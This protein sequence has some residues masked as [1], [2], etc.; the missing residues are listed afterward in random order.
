MSDLLAILVIAA[1][2]LLLFLLAVAESSLNGMSRSRANALA[3][4][5]V[6]GAS[7]LARGLEDRGLLLAP[8]LALALASQLSVGALVG[9]VVSR[10]FGAGWVPVG[11]L[12]ALLVMFVATEAVPKSWALRNIDRA[13]IRSARASTCLLYTSPSPRDA[14]LSRM[15]S[16]A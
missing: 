13:A 15:P 1:L 4:E 11:I 16:S 12:V 10:R 7:A 3:E 9:L 6:D 5:K 14:T 2:W 8:I